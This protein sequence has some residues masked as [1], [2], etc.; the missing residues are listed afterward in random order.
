MNIRQGLKEFAEHIPYGIGKYLAYVPFPLRLGKA[1]NENV[2]LINRL[3]GDVKAEDEFIIEGLNDIVN[4]ARNN[5]KC[6][7]ELYKKAGVLDLNIRSFEDFKKLPGTDKDFFRL[8]MPEFSGAY[9]LNT[10]GTTGSPFMFYTDKNCWAREWAHMHRIWASLGYDYRIPKMTLRGKN[11]GNRN[12]IYNPVHNE[13]I[14]NT[15]KPFTELE[16]DILYIIKKCGVKYLHGYPSTVYNFICEAEEKYSEEEI[17][18][19][20]SGLKGLLLSSE[21]PHPYMTDKFDKYGLPFVSWYGHSEMC[22]LAYNKGKFHNLYE[23]F[24]TYGYAEVSGNG[25]LFGTSYRNYDMPL[26]R[27]DTG[28]LVKCEKTTESGRCS[29]FSVTAG[30]SGDFVTDSE[31]K[32]ISLTALIFG[33]HHRAFDYARFIQVSQKVP[34]KMTVYMVPSGKGEFVPE[35]LFDMTNI[36]VDCDYRIIPKPILTGAGKLKLKIEEI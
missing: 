32:M 2:S 33:R 29:A 13:F 36:S 20:F 10:G 15:Y 25:H 1:Y 17:S 5:F 28:D 7:H 18:S 8:N 27:Y 6:Y 24:A 19:L 34:G 35:Q 3:S 11:I 22:V 9:K 12:Y 16:A 26:I 23:P 14:L 21:Y 31:G 4:Y 30:R